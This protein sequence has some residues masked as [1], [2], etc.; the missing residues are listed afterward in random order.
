MQSCLVKGYNI[1]R[2]PRAG[3]RGQ[4]S[5]DRRH[6]V[7]CFRWWLRRARCCFETKWTGKRAELFRVP[8]GIR[9]Q[10]CPIGVILFLGIGIS[11]YSKQPSFHRE[12]GAWWVSWGHWLPFV[13][14]LSLATLQSGSKMLNDFLSPFP[15]IKARALHMWGKCPATELYPQSNNWFSKIDQLKRL[16]TS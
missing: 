10:W 11:I 1:G 3:D 4:N 13:P 15:G 12:A 14:V 5:R 6:S 8:P 9:E 7:M 16:T 2:A